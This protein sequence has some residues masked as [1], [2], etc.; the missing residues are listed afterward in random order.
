LFYKPDSIRYTLNQTDSI[1]PHLTD[2]S[3]HY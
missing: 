1:A 3:F 2:L